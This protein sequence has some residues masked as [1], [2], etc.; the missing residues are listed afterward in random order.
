MIGK[1]KRETEVIIR[2]EE[3]SPLK[4]AQADDRVI[5]RQYFESRF[6]PLEEEFTSTREPGEN[7]ES[8][9][10]ESDAESTSGWEGLSG[11]ESGAHIEVIEYGSKQL[12]TNSSDKLPEAKAFMVGRP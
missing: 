3:A 12:S 4:A 6:E 11:E 8:L 5:F 9:E 7:N 10:I 2:P 1:R